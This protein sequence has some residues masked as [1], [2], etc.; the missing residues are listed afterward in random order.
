MTSM[1]AVRWNVA[2][3]ADNDQSFRLFLAGQDWGRK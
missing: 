1:A 3:S 2:V